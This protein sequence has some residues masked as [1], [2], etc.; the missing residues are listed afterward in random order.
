MRGFNRFYTRRIGVLQEGLRESPYSLAEVRI[1]Y[2]L[3]HRDGLAASDLAS[4]L[5]LDAGYLS[6]ILMRFSRRGLVT[7]TRSTDDARVHLIRLT[8]K[9]RAAF[10]P[11]ERRSQQ[12]IAELLGTLPDASQR[13]LIGAMHT[14]ETLLAEPAVPPPPCLLRTHAPGDIG[15]IIGRH[16]ALYAQEYGWDA[17]F[18]ALVAEIAAKFIHEFDPERERCWIAEYR[19]E[20]VGSAFVVRKSATV[21]KL[22]LLLVTPGARGLGL[23]KQ[24]VDA[25]VDF[26]KASG[27]RKLTLWTQQNL[28]AARHIYQQ[29]GFTCV[30]REPHHSFGHALVGETWEKALQL[31]SRLQPPSSKAI[32]ART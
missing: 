1:L 16:G 2:E 24:L 11:L 18:E 6:R 26:A 9:G 14:I 29:A 19:G 12:E 25:C 31:P 17:G 15:W 30:R 20:R 22:R 5:L 4:E 7:R 28:A 10:A 32:A 8:S 23:G 21:A 27:Y 13:Q 3:A